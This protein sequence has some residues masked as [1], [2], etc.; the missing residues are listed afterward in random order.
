M[1]RILDAFN[2][3]DRDSMDPSLASLLDALPADS[4]VGAQPPQ[5]T[6]AEPDPPESDR[7]G[8]SPAPE[9]EGPPSPRT[10]PPPPPAA[11][12]R[13][14]DADHASRV[15]VCSLTNRTSAPLMPFGEADWAAGEQYRMARTKIVQHPKR[16]RLIVVSSPAPGDG[17][18]ITAINLAGALAL[19]SEGKVLLV[20][21]DLRRS[22]ICALLEL[23]ESP[24]LADVL[25]GSS[26]LESALIQVK[27]HSRF[28]VL[29]AG[30][31]VLNPTELFDSTEWASIVATL[32]AK[33][34]YVIIDS[35]SVG[36]VADY[37][38]IQ[39]Q[40]DGV[41]I[42]LRQDHTDRKSAF[43][44]VESVPRDKLIGVVLNCV[45]DWILQRR[46]SSHY[47][48]YRMRKAAP[49]EGAD[50]RPKARQ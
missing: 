8:S 28:F 44:A 22:S 48:T 34:Q 14:A 30:E 11:S 40:C 47:F 29:P 9:A 41:V 6:P 42:V 17:K 27:Q 10:V 33:F 25:S 3:F 20:D 5:A 19:K 7:A 37:D 45:T 38:L 26:S 35:P 43:K 13:A 2:R 32:R 46:K 21:G 12:V 39:A 49:P 23:P 4:P 18:S 50:A 16:P 24:G 31:T 36:I 1:G 15:R